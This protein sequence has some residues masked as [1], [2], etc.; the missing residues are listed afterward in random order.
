YAEHSPSRRHSEGLLNGRLSGQL[1]HV[2]AIL[3]RLPKLVVLN[4]R[5]THRLTW[6]RRERCKRQVAR[7]SRQQSRRWLQLT[8]SPAD[9]IRSERVTGYDG[10]LG[11]TARQALKCPVFKA[12]RSGRNIDRQHA[13]LASRAARR[14]DG[15]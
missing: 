7:A 10:F 4:A 14:L 8:L 5:A 9:R 2:N 15:R 12:I 6:P 1:P 3:R 13:R 11:M